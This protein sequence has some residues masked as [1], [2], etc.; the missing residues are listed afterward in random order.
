MQQKLLRYLKKRGV[1]ESLTQT[2]LPGAND[3]RYQPTINIHNLTD[4][5]RA[6]LQ[7]GQWVATTDQVTKP[8]ERGIYL[9]IK[10]SGSVVVAWH[11]NAKGH[12]YRV[13]VKTLRA[14]ARA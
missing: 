7:V 4:T 5:Q 10:P 6:A 12:N 8:E 11:G 13:Y 1:I 9:G 14:Y 2:A 3:M